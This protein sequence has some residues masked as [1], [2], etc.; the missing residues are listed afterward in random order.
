[1]MQCQKSRTFHC[2]SCFG[3]CNKFGSCLFG[4]NT[5]QDNEF[6]RMRRCTPLITECVRLTIVDALLM[7]TSVPSKQPFFT[8]YLYATNHIHIIDIQYSLWNYYGVHQETLLTLNFWSPAVH[9]IWVR[10]IMALPYSCA[11]G[12][13]FTA[14]RSFHLVLVNI[15]R[16]SQ[17]SLFSFCFSI[18]M[19]YHTPIQI[20]QPSPQNLCGE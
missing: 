14:C 1:M 13:Q 11:F 12:L 7:L 17:L 15:A 8:Q 6:G 18:C 10:D 2:C 3:C 19:T 4:N 5:D 16:H 20:S 9:A